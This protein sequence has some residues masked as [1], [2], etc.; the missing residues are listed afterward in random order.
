MET[1]NHNM[2]ERLTGRQAEI[3]KF[4]SDTIR[5]RRIPPS[6]RE[7]GKQF[8]ITSPNGVNCHINQLIHKGYV[9]REYNR[10]RALRI[11]D[12]EPKGVPLYEMNDDRLKELRYRDVK[13]D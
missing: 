7:I 10:S 4:V 6:V 12:S 11:V 8:G 1:T 3:F 9:A 5:K 2:R 13:S